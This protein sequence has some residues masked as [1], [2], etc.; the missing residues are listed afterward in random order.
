LG[1]KNTVQSVERA[2]DLLYCFSIK[3]FELSISDFVDKTKLNRTT[4]FRLLA[5]LEEKGVVNKNNRTGL[6]SLG[7]RMISFAQIV[8]ENFDVRREAL[9]YLKRISKQTGE[10][11]SL[12]ILRSGRR[13]CIEKVEGTEDIRQF[14]QLGNPYYL[15]KGASGKVLLAFHSDEEIEEV[16][17][18]WETIHKT[19]I[20]RMNYFD[21]LKKIRENETAISEGE[22][23]FGA[24]SISA[25]ILNADNKPIAGLSISSLSIRLTDKEKKEYRELVR[26]AVKEIS[27][28]YRYSI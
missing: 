18:E 7:Y 5:T 4:V 8:N 3:E 11:V 16:I 2:I 28:K 26:N 12:N 21:E 1:K 15:V 20:D 10:T 25:P 9:P 22:R 24:I 27:G 19:T 13:V 6:Y 14:V 23:V 17:R